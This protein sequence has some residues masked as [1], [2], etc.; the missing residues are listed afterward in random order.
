MGKKRLQQMTMLGSFPG[1]E[2]DPAGHFAH[3][4]T[5]S[6]N[7]L[8]EAGGNLRTTLVTVDKET[9]SWF[10]LRVEMDES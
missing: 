1:M 10:L 2:K 6:I 5:Q 4:I 8:Y 7:D 9:E 3:A